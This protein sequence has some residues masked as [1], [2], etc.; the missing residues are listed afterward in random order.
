MTT[1]DVRDVRD[2][3][4]DGISRVLYFIRA[5]AKKEITTLYYEYITTTVSTTLVVQLTTTHTTTQTKMF[6]S[7]RVLYFVRAGGNLPLFFLCVL[8]LPS[9]FLHN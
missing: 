7:S 6:V 3:S 2:D 5:I 9:H 8:F 4:N 1:I